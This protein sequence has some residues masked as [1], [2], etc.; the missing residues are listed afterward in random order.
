M[1]LEKNQGNDQPEIFPEDLLHGVSETLPL[2]SH[3]LRRIFKG[4]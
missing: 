4:D 1:N 3:S 2:H